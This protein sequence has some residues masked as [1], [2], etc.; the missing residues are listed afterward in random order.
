MKTMP[1]NSES[2]ASCGASP[3]TRVTSSASAP[4]TPPSAGPSPPLGAR[5]PVGI[6]AEVRDAGAST[7]GRTGSQ[8]LRMD[9][10]PPCR[11][12]PLFG[13]RKATRFLVIDMEWSSTSVKCPTSIEWDVVK[14]N[15]FEPSLEIRRKK[16]QFAAYGYLG[17]V[18]EGNHWHFLDTIVTHERCT[19]SFGYNARPFKLRFARLRSILSV[20]L[21]LSNRTLSYHIVSYQ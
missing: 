9:R 21:I 19:V 6:P 15:T 5:V 14:H 11:L 16:M 4:A 12:G 17:I 1:R 2:N 20:S 8:K 10:L 3:P 18:K 7:A 13:N